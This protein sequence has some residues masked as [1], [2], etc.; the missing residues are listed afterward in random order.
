[1]EALKKL[2]F[3]KSINREDHQ[4]SIELANT[5]KELPE[6]VQNIVQAGGRVIEVTE[7]HHSLEEIYLNLVREEAKP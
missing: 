7:A 4:L 6:L 2:T 3:V 1:M 5:E